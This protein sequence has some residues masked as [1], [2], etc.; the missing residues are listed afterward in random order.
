MR[1]V[2]RVSGK[3]K[4]Y[5]LQNALAAVI[6][7]RTW[8]GCSLSAL[9]SFAAARP[10]IATDVPGLSHL[11]PLG[12]NG[13]LVPPN[14]AEALSETITHV[15][16]HPERAEPV[17]KQAYDFV[18]DYSWEKIAAKHLELYQQLIAKPEVPE[19]PEEKKVVG[20]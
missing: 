8:E 17:G 13:V 18:K 5:L 16:Q 3:K 10:V 14:S 1:F 7:T 9:E 15:F 2:G 19:Q 4:V 20:L 11:F 12:R 6:P